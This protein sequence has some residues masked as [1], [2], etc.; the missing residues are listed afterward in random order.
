MTAAGQTDA[1]LTRSTALPTYHLDFS[2]FPCILESESVRNDF[3][4]AFH[5]PP[6]VFFS[7]VEGLDD[8]QYRQ[9][10][11]MVLGHARG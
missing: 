5:S 2:I 4:T 1:A 6:M 10:G 11:V 7:T 3:F 9:F 8:M